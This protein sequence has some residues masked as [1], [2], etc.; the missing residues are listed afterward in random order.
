[1]NGLEGFLRTDPD[2]AGCE[3][4]MRLLHMYAEEVFAG[5]DAARIHPGLATHLRACAPC[6]QD[7][8]ALLLAVSVR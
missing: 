2:D 3:E 6:A 8:E 1:M 4:T 7:L 5:G